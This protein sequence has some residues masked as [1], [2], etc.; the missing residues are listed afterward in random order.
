MTTHV[1]HKEGEKAVISVIAVTGTLKIRLFNNLFTPALTNVKAD[2]SEATF[3]GY[4]PKVADVTALG[5]LAWD[6]SNNAYGQIAAQTF[7]CSSTPGSPETI[8]GW[9]MTLEDSGGTDRVV[10]SHKFT[11]PA[12]IATAGDQVKFDFTLYVGDLASV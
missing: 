9:Y 10:C 4:A 8:Y 1:T 7:T 2:F 3:G 11:T 6:V 12:V 5:T